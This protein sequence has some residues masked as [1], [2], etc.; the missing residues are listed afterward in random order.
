[1]AGVPAEP[2]A[3]AHGEAR[4]LLAGLLGLLRDHEPLG[5]GVADDPQ[6][7]R[8]LV[9]A[10]LDR[11]GERRHA[12]RGKVPPAQVELLGPDDEAHVVARTVPSP[13]LRDP[14]GPP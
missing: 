4:A 1:M 7:A 13:A 11:H 10:V 8:A 14:R 9:D 3:A 6:G 12:A 5:R 2:G